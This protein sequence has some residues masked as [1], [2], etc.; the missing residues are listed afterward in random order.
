[1]IGSRAELVEKSIET[2][3]ETIDLHR[4]YVD[5]VHIKCLK[6]GKKMN[7][8]PSNKGLLV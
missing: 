8:V 7:R 5:N 2:I 4:P 6:C 3:D 1:M